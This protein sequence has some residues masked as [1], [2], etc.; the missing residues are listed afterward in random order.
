M[1]VLTHE[2]ILEQD[3]WGR[4]EPVSLGGPIRS[5]LAPPVEEKGDS[6]VFR[7]TAMAIDRFYLAILK[8]APYLYRRV[9]ETEVEVYGLSE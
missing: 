6:I 7:P 9:S 2:R 5:L 1:P 4:E 3:N 8:G